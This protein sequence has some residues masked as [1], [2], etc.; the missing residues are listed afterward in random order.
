M[1]SASIIAQIFMS[2]RQKDCCGLE[3]DTLSP[4]SSRL[5]QK[6]SH[7]DLK[8]LIGRKASTNT[9]TSNKNSNSCYGHLSHMRIAYA[10]MPPLNTHT[11]VSSKASGQKSIPSL[12]YNNYNTVCMR[13]VKV[14]VKTCLSLCCCHCDKYHCYMTGENPVS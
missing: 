7:D 14:Y 12:L 2:L 10:R 3:Q 4:F 13:A 8:L 6:T 9:N 1:S 11:D 5:T